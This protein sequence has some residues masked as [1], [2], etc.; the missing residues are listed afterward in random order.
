MEEF[1]IEKNPKAPAVIVIIL[2]IFWIISM[3]LAIFV[4]IIGIIIVVNIITVG[5]ASFLILRSVIEKKI[6]VIDDNGLRLYRG[7]DLTQKIE[8]TNVERIESFDQ[9]Y[10]DF[11]F[12]IIVKK[13]LHFKPDSYFFHANDMRAALEKVKEATAGMGIEFIHHDNR[14][15]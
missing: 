12:H 14:F 13:G 11:M 9:S 7:K 5:I 10:H 4:G 3:F 8:W 15:L 2:I 6:L 1:R